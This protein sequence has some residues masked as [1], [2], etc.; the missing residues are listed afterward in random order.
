M[1]ISDLEGKEKTNMEELLESKSTELGVDS[2]EGHSGGDYKLLKDLIGI[3]YNCK[4]LNY[5]KTEFQNVY[6]RCGHYEMILHGQ[7][8]IVECN[9]HTPRGVL[10]LTEMYSLATLIDLDKPMVKGFISTDP[11]LMSKKK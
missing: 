9:N 5:C 8:R 11:K 7:N 3:C 10:S 6:A 2:Y 4:S 1:K